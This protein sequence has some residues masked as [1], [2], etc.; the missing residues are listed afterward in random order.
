MLVLLVVA[1]AVAAGRVPRIAAKS[2]LAGLLAALAAGAVFV[3][4]LPA[5][6]ETSVDRGLVLYVVAL[7]LGLAAAVTVLRAPRCARC[8]PARRL[9]ALTRRRRRS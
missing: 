2:T 6:G 3:T 1:G 7:A 8:R 5:L 9:R 4:G